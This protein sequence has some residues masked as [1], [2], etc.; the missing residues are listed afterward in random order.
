MAW[1]KRAG[2]RKYF[3]LCKRLPDGR[4][5]KQ[6]FGKG[7]RAEVES[8]RLEFKVR[9]REQEKIRRS[10]FESLDSLADECMTA[11]V[12]LFEAHLFAA[13][14]HNPKSRGWRKRRS[15]QMIKQMEYEQDKQENTEPE[16]AETVTEQVTLQEVIRRCRSGDRNAVVALRRVMQ[17]HPDLFSSLGHITAK[18]QT[19]WIRA[20]SGPDLFEREM[21]LKTTRELRQGL[22]G[23]GS[24]SHLEKLAAEQVI[25]THLEQGFHQLIEARCV[26]K[27]VD[28]PKYQV[29]ASQCAAKRHEKALAA[30]TTIQAIK[31][32]QT[33]IDPIRPAEPPKESSKAD[34]RTRTH[35]G[36]NRISGAFDKQH[37]ELLTK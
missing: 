33:A 2:G 6:Y 11:F 31:S 24:G 4:V 21:M 36:A 10:K 27:G 9:E 23:E 37:Q 28:L 15:G 35:L 32:Q 29:E 19:E 26:G 5:H 30:L 22:I 1:E 8:M 3:Y 14:Y 16:S 13:G 12:Q 25:T 17:D 18:V 7:P 34:I 20:I